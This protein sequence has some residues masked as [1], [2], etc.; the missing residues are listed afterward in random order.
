M[1]KSTQYM[2]TRKMAATLVAC[3][4]CF[5]VAFGCA[6]NLLPDGHEAIVEYLQ[7]QDSKP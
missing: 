4:A 5:V 3:A 7:D 1:K 2:R 6:W